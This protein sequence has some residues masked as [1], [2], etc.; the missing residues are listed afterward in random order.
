MDLKD[1]WLIKQIKIITT[2]K[3]KLKKIKAKEV[4]KK[5]KQDKN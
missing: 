4:K 5:A 2:L 3:V 1:Q